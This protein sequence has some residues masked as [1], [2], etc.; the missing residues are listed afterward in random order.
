M[1]VQLRQLV[2][3]TGAVKHGLVS[4]PD[5]G[6]FGSPDHP[7]I[8]V[9]CAWMDARLPHIC[10]YTEAYHKL[11]PGATV[12]VLRSYNDYFIRS[13]ETTIRAMIPVAKLLQD[14][15]QQQKEEKENRILVH[16]FS[17]GGCFM[18]LSLI[19][20][21]SSITKLP[22]TKATPFPAGAIIFD[23]CPWDGAILPAVRAF[24]A[25][26]T[27]PLLK[28]P[29]RALL[30]LFIL[31]IRLRGLLSKSGDVLYVMRGRL[32]DDSV[33]PQTA[34]RTYLYSKGD[35]VIRSQAVEAHA[36]ASRQA[37]FSVE[38]VDFEK[39]PHVNHMAKN[40]E[41][42]LDL[43]RKTWERSTRVV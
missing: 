13:S 3:I 21:T 18:L 15:R 19:D 34:P 10:K 17:N 16:A 7:K 9:I 29:F 6:V 43:V 31:Y 12:I 35:Q 33:L 23:S 1:A 38:I 2:P 11:Y 5:P 14:I 28:Y 41:R 37:G 42:Y 27:N 25:G 30:I 8:I 24:S 32:L 4:Y 20:A 22:A 40:A 39:T 26:I 36:E